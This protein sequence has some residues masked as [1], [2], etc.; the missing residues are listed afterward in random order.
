MVMNQRSAKDTQNE[1][2]T[3]DINRELLI[4]RETDQ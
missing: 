4:N 1:H 3:L 2:I